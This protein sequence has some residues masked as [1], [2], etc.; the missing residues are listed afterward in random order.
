MDNILK[1][2]KRC[3]ATSG[4]VIFAVIG[5]QH[6]CIALP[7]TAAAAF[8]DLSSSLQQLHASSRPLVSVR[9]SQIKFH[10]SSTLLPSVMTL[11][12]FIFYLLLSVCRLLP[13]ILFTTPVVSVPPRSDI[14]VHVRDV[15][16]RKS[17]LG[18][19]YFC[20]EVLELRRGCNCGNG[21][22]G[23]SG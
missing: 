7:Q 13:L 2:Q 11:D 4:P 1:R 17:S 22:R 15:W 3:L 19:C 20:L 21:R 12:V 9:F 16:V 5:R 23:R 8:C 18:L 14:I 6:L 10:P